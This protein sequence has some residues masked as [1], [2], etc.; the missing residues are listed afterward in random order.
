MINFKC[1]FRMKHVFVAHITQYVGSPNILT[2]DFL[3]PGS[4]GASW[5][6][7]Q[8]KW[9]NWTRTWTRSNC[10]GFKSATAPT[11]PW[12]DSVP[13]AGLL[14]A[15]EEHNN[16]EHFILLGTLEALFKLSDK[17]G[18]EKSCTFPYV[19]F[20]TFSETFCH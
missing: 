11:S 6:K 7:K 5:L 2:W 10:T 18:R 9:M 3:K 4:Q 19:L 16:I 8:A 17:H 15:T 20:L 13:L 14:Q 12:S 1:M